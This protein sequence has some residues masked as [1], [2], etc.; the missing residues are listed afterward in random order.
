[1]R[2]RVHSTLLRRCESFSLAFGDAECG[3]CL[4]VRSPLHQPPSRGR[5]REERESSAA[6]VLLHSIEGK[7]RRGGG[8]GSDGRRRL[9][10]RARR[11]SKRGRR[12]S[13]P[14]YY[15]SAYWA[16]HTC[17]GRQPP[18]ML[19]LHVFAG[20]KALPRYEGGISASRTERETH[21]QQPSDNA[22]IS[23]LTRAKTN[24]QVFLGTATATQ[25]GEKPRNNSKRDWRS[26]VANP[27]WL[28]H[29]AALRGT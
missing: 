10:L 1:M 8:K 5:R 22:M 25:Q 21:S 23:S 20:Q 6:A 14:W 18:L 24:K 16:G 2:T 3:L 27:L 4:G 17:S 12:A 28:K 11:S 15:G 13:Q 9:P 19:K 26:I 7:A 29:D